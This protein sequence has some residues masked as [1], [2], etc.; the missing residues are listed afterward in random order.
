MKGLNPKK[1]SALFQNNC[2]THFK[3]YKAGRRWLIAGISILSGL[4]GGSALTATTAKAQTLTP[5]AGQQ[6]APED[7]TA[8]QTS[9]TIPATSQ[10]ASEVPSAE[11]T[12]S[13]SGTTSS[14][15]V[16]QSH[17]SGSAVSA[18]STSTSESVELMA[19]EETDQSNA[20]TATSL[21]TS[22]QSVVDSQA[23]ANSTT[24]S[25]AAR[26][27]P[28][29]PQAYAFSFEKYVPDPSA[30]VDVAS[31]NKGQTEAS[32][33]IS[34]I[35]AHFTST[36]GLGILHILMD[37]SI[38]GVSETI[39]KN[40]KKMA[41]LMDL[42]Y[43]KKDFQYNDP[44]GTPVWYNGVI[45][46][47]AAN[48]LIYHDFNLGYADYL[49]SFAEGISDWVTGIKAK[50]QSKDTSVADGLI[51]Y[52]HY[53]GTQLAGNSGL[54]GQ[55]GAA[56]T[57]FLTWLKRI[58]T[59]NNYA[60]NILKYEGNP[61][62]VANPDVDSAVNAINF[63][64]SIVAP[65]IIN[66]VAH[67]AL[68]DV[69]AIGGHIKDGDYAPNLLKDAVNLNVNVT[70]M[71]QDIGL[72]DVLGTSIIQNVYEGIR[73]NAQNAIERNWSIGASKALTDA[74]NGR[75]AT[76]VRSPYSGTPGYS[77][78][79]PQSILDDGTG[80]V[81]LSQ[82]A[83][84]AG[85][86]WYRKLIT[87]V[88]KQAGIDAQRNAPQTT[89]AG[90]IDEV[91]A[92]LIKTPDPDNAP[93]SDN[94]KK[95]ILVDNVTHSFGSAKSYNRN[96]IGVR[97]VITKIYN[98]EYQA[99]Q[100]VIADY[101]Q[102][103]ALSD[104]EIL[105][106]Q[107]QYRFVNPAD[108]NK[109]DLNNYSL[110]YKY[111]RNKNVAYLAMQLADQQVLQNKDDKPISDKTNKELTESFNAD[112]PGIFNMGMDLDNFA[113]KD[114]L[115]G[116]M[117]IRNYKN[118]YEDELTAAKNALA[119]GK[120]FAK[121]HYG[122]LANGLMQ[123]VDQ[124]KMDEGSFKNDGTANKYLNY[125]SPKWGGEPVPTVD[126]NDVQ[127][128]QI[129]SKGYQSQLQPIHLVFQSADKRFKDVQAKLYASLGVTATTDPTYGSVYYTLAGRDVNIKAPSIAGW[130]AGQQTVTSDGIPQVTF[131]YT[132]S[133]NAQLSQLGTQ[134]GTYNRQPASDQLTD[135][136][137]TVSWADGK[138]KT[139][140]IAK[141]YLTVDKN[142]THVGSY[143]YHLNQDGIAYVI[144]QLTS[145]TATLQNGDKLPTEDDLA[146]VTG[147]FNLQQAQNGRFLPHLVLKPATVVQGQ[148]PTIDELV[149]SA[150]D[151][152]KNAID[153]RQ[154]TMDP[155]DWATMGSQSVNLT[156]TDPTSQQKVTATTMVNVISQETSTATMDS[157]TTQSQSFSLVTDSESSASDATA[158]ANSQLT[159]VASQE[160]SLT[161][162]S[163]SDQSIVTS[164][165]NSTN[166]LVDQLASANSALDSR[167]VASDSRNIAATEN[168]THKVVQ[169]LSQALHV[170][171]NEASLAS[172][173]VASLSQQSASLSA[174]QSEIN[175]QLSQ[176]QSAEQSQVAAASQSRSQAIDNETSQSRQTSQV[177]SK[178]AS[179]VGS[180]ASLIASQSQ[181][182]SSHQSQL[183]SLADLQK[184]LIDQSQAVA[185]QLTIASDASANLAQMVKPNKD[186]EN[187]IEQSLAELS[188]KTASVSDALVAHAHTSDHLQQQT[189]LDQSLSVTGSLSQAS[190]IT[191]SQSQVV[192]SVSER[193]ASA[194]SFASELSRA[195]A[196]VAQQSVAN[197]QS[198]TSM[199]QVESNIASVFSAD[200]SQSLTSQSQAS[201]SVIAQSQA[202]LVSA[203]QSAD[204]QISQLNAHFQSLQS[205]LSTASQAYSQAS[206]SQSQAT[207]KRQ[208]LS[209][210]VTQQASQQ[211]LVVQTS[212]SAADNFGSR[213]IADISQS[214]TRPDL[215]TA[216]K[217]A[218][219][220]AQAS[221]STAADQRNSQ[222][223]AQQS[224][225][226]Q[227]LS[228]AA[229]DSQSAASDLASQQASNSRLGST[230]GS[231]SQR[232]S[233]SAASQSRVIAQASQSL[234]AGA[235]SLA[236]QQAAY[237]RDSQA[238]TTPTADQSLALVQAGQHE[239]ANSV[240]LTSQAAQVLI[241]QTSLI[242]TS[243]DQQSQWGPALTSLIS[244]ANASTSMVSS[245]AQRDR[246]AGQTAQTSVLAQSQATAQLSQR[247]Q[248]ALASVST[249]ASELTSRA[250]ASVSQIESMQSQSALQQTQKQQAAAHR[251]TE[252][253][254]TSNDLAQRSQTDQAQWTQP[255]H[256]KQEASLSLAL[257]TAG[258]QSQAQTSAQWSLIHTSLSAASLVE[259]T[260]QSTW[261]VIQASLTANPQ[262]PAV[263]VTAANSAA[264]SL[265]QLSEQNVAELSQLADQSTSQGDASTADSLRSLSVLAT[266]D[267]ARTSLAQV[268]QSVSSQRHQLVA[269]QQSMTQQINARQHDFQ[270]AQ[271]SLG[272]AVTAWQ[273]TSQAQ[274]ATDS[275]GQASLTSAAVS[276]SLDSL[277]ATSL[278]LSNAESVLSLTLIDQAEQSS[279]NAAGQALT[280]LYETS[281]SE[282]SQSEQ[283]AFTDWHAQQAESTTMAHTLTSMAASLKSANQSVS[284]VM[285]QATASVSADVSQQVAGQSTSYQDWRHQSQALVTHQ[286]GLLTTAQHQAEQVAAQGEQETAAQPSVT[287]LTTQLTATTHQSLAQAASQRS[288]V[289]VSLS[290]QSAFGQSQVSAWTQVQQSLA[291]QAQVPA[292]ELSAL[293]SAQTSLSAQSQTD[294]AT[295]SLVTAQRESLVATS[296]LDGATSL[297]LTDQQAQTSLALAQA[298]LAVAQQSRT[299]QATVTAQAQASAAAAQDFQRS[300]TSMTAQV[301]AG[302]HFQQGVL[303]Q[304]PVEI[305]S[306]L[307][308]NSVLTSLSLLSVA[309]TSVS[310]D[311]DWA[312]ISLASASQSLTSQALQANVSLLSQAA[313]S[314]SD[315]SARWQAQTSALTSAQR[316]IHAVSQA[317]Q[318]LTQ[319]RSL[320]STSLVV[321]ASQAAS[322]S[323]SLSLSVQVAS[324]LSQ[325]IQIDSQL[326]SQASAAS[327]RQ[328]VTTSV[329]DSLQ[330]QDS[331]LRSTAVVQSQHSLSALASQSVQASQMV[332]HTAS[333]PSA[334]STWTSVAASL[335]AHLSTVTSQL[336]QSA[337]TS[338]S[339][340][341]ATRQSAEQAAS[342]VAS[343]SRV[344]ASLT[345]QSQSV[346]TQLT[347]AASQLQSGAQSLL[348]SL[349]TTI[350]QLSAASTASLSLTQDHQAATP[351]EQSQVTSL[352]TQ[353]AGA[354]SDLLTNSQS[355]HSLA[356][357]SV[358]EA[359]RSLADRSR[360][361][362]S[363]A[364]SLATATHSMGQ[365]A[366]ALASVAQAT[367]T[368]ATSLSTTSQQIQSAQTSQSVVASRSATSLSLA[369]QR[370]QSV[371][372]SESVATS[373]ADTS[374]SLASQQTQSALASQSLA[375]AHNQ[376]LPVV[377]A[378]G[379]G[380]AAP[381]SPLG[382]SRPQPTPLSPQIVAGQGSQL[383]HTGGHQAH[384]FTTKHPRF[385]RFR[386]TGV[387][388]LGLYRSPNFSRHTR[389]TWY[390]QRARTHQPMFEVL[391][392]THSAHGTLRYK[393]RD[394]NRYSP[395][396]GLV[397]Y[398]TTR[399]AYVKPTYY[400]HHKRTHVITVINAR[401][402]N[403]YHTAKLAGRHLH[404]RQG[405]H[406]AV[407]RLVRHGQT[408]R[409]Q[410]TNGRYVT[411]NKQW[412]YRGRPQNIQR[413]TLPHQVWR[414]QTAGSHW[415]VVV[416]HV[417]T[418]PMTR[419]RLPHGVALTVTPLVTH[420][421]PHPVNWWG[422]RFIATP[423]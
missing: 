326:K 382:T 131:T 285:S 137:L 317:L 30:K 275:A 423:K 388:K 389:L 397:G 19:A 96:G 106:K 400:Q 36:G 246:D 130:V 301:T 349:A 168:Q 140:G 386:V 67:Q 58:F 344:Q 335:S 267:D 146:K 129:F 387:K 76:R 323:A 98:S 126:P 257:A 51:N 224:T 14:V 117:L 79:N 142:A 324:Q 15:A 311:Q 233:Q 104:D 334:H 185:S 341:S 127:S 195:E 406:L 381:T 74:F 330:L 320:T 119:A 364:A 223:T 108:G 147:T 77:E 404:Y 289:D 415:P 343:R 414:F 56:G 293:G 336:A 144:D 21:S 253:V 238:E 339:A 297:L 85:Y 220:S 361:A 207:A 81:P 99:I 369:S 329:Q 171:S 82:V 109:F 266:T 32:S 65:V 402:I 84:A 277:S 113:V 418:L 190:L 409:Y 306:S 421:S 44:Y 376:P 383:V 103:P 269:S 63:Y 139:L 177:A 350:S 299:D 236:S 49:R 413:L 93:L 368:A 8:T 133:K 40:I 10:S 245:A 16:S 48:N 95:Q 157:L 276:L 218:F 115:F 123:S 373:Q 46:K 354:T 150:T 281:A 395:T 188:K 35:V 97:Q 27:V 38:Q 408:T 87:L 338:L 254:T 264:T 156:L 173:G 2:K 128:G 222:W 243:L 298:Q 121:E 399:S 5:G 209:N 134:Y 284:A 280:S 45:G 398:I 176:S 20:V 214:L 353:A 295:Q 54:L 114:S 380:N 315:Q 282:Q 241:S 300:A 229:R 47:S 31:Y 221:L 296:V 327:Q 124:A 370:V 68:S 158:S 28:V 92:S 163:A 360:A 321:L 312:Q 110:I 178:I 302:D 294:A 91:N 379:A 308:L 111:L 403:G 13:A 348:S 86:A 225:Y 174:S 83:Q 392:R 393:V 208:S 351:G 237:T 3:M 211:S 105:K 411:A 394:I 189:S 94:E 271:Q 248:S 37:P 25:E 6:V 138:S 179:Q 259:W 316:A 332:D 149:V 420:Q 135:T 71:L 278:S 26:K 182:A 314:A 12:T 303:A 228:Q 215:T 22:D 273:K 346:V 1:Q 116:S 88:V 72:Y 180:G 53:D 355:Q 118:I 262:A 153:H 69:R 17:V 55:A 78:S 50:A 374:L 371:Q 70:K 283:R 75:P 365:Q 310:L 24:F 242:Q 61:H 251:Q 357:V 202:S 196:S 213:E 391:G 231:L 419:Y 247:V 34:N 274:P 201:L 235:E 377:P 43:Q 175:H 291:Q 250:L 164:L 29:A 9:M 172:Q 318:S 372:T 359:E 304:Q 210:R 100:A 80:K 102:A 23:T 212:L 136:A 186:I 199:R 279:V 261:S 401:G 227:A 263:Q 170:S 59:T 416:R 167:N 39:T 412:V 345:S 193:S 60:G 407:K 200:Q 11:T 258:Q 363:L 204:S 322:T 120:T 340:A 396:Y 191:A 181:V 375:A 42:F 378:P 232:L 292:A 125:V 390:A 33:Q 337:Q 234:S 66:G 62:N 64:T 305:K 286:N 239:I 358:A 7:V 165:E 252:L 184:S 145:S 260:Q 122:K 290:E 307:A 244:L 422:V 217:S 226:S 57:T 112:V 342:V 410:L 347:S 161:T 287:S 313:T 272:Q 367:S 319:R 52:G 162:Q 73:M 249:V 385:K 192:A 160:Q 203:S 4:L 152:Q 198:L 328:S 219:T 366:H 89:V 384:H 206:R 325:Q 183:S 417:T 268:S 255:Q 132:L 143:K 41:D 155:H 148:A 405:Q 240:S 141:Q 194:V 205:Q 333:A 18:T 151:D 331:Q 197:Q 309:K 107:S 166:S 159:S 256:L 187:K 362:M 265:S 356:Q 154:I 352:L 90:I 216:Q 101:Q 169:S 288:L 230:V 270:T